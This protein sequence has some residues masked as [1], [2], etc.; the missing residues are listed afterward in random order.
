MRWDA[1]PRPRFYRHF[2]WYP[3]RIGKQ[4]VWWE[5]VKYEVFYGGYGDSCREYSLLDDTDD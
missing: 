3:I 4:W 2:A 1:P 5:W